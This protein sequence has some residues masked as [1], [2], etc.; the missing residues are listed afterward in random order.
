[1]LCLKI[2]FRNFFYKFIISEKM[3]KLNMNIIDMLKTTNSKNP[4]LISYERR[5]TYFLT[6]IEILEVL[7]KELSEK[8]ILEIVITKLQLS[9]P[10][11]DKNAYYQ[12]ATE[13]SVVFHMFC[14]KHIVFGYEKRLL[15]DSEK[16]PECSV[17]TINN[18]VYNAEA[19]CPQ[20]DFIDTEKKLIERRIV[21]KNVGR[22]PLKKDAEVNFNLL[23][24]ELESKDLNLNVVKFKNNDNKLKDFLVS[25][26]N[27][28]PQADSPKEL[29]L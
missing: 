8:E 10:T 1:M 19:K 9:K 25:A 6:F 2:R 7:K 16:Q 23:K 24:R 27:K 15:K 13:L 22:A 28:F 26:N 29:N 18:F 21:I 5:T 20:R 11:F 14:Y 12:A 4:L 17:T 3:R